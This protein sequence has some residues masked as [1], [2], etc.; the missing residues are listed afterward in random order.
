M[1]KKHLFYLT[2]CCFTA[3]SCGTVPLPLT[4]IPE[5]GN[6]AMAAV[7]AGWNGANVQAAYATKNK[8]VFNLSFQH[9]I[10]RAHDASRM[11]DAGVGVVSRSGNFMGMLSMGY[12][13][14]Y[15]NTFTLGSSDGIHRQFG[16]VGR[17]SGYMTSRVSP[18]SFLHL[19]VSNY[20]GSLTF[21]R[22][23][24]Y[25]Y[26]DVKKFS[27]LG[28]EMAYLE[29]YGNFFCGAGSHGIIDFSKKDKEA[30]F[31]P[32]PVWAVIGL[33]FGKDW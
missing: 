21:F 29:K 30:T 14:Q 23:S 8:V 9:W 3:F 2:L 11:L 28:I 25:Y 6:S 15:I 12:G 16:P 5:E 27:N 22:N 10:W 24:G 7:A 26:A 1:Y 17:W 13:R 32:W 18:H 31:R 19:R 33:Q 4:T 20:W